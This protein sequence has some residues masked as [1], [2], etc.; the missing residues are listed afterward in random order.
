MAL[1]P[2]ASRRRSTA[3][4]LGEAGDAAIAIAI[5]TLLALPSPSFFHL[6]GIQLAELSSVF[7]LEVAR[8]EKVGTDLLTSRV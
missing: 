4:L 3:A 8:D 5:A 1:A 2:R 7:P 6:C